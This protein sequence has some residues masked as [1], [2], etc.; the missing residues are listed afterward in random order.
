MS[1]DGDSND[2]ASDYSDITHINNKLRYIR[3]TIENKNILN[4]TITATNQKLI[5]NNFLLF[6][7]LFSL[8]HGTVIACLS[9]ATARLGDDLGS[10]QS[11][12]MY[13]SYTLSALLGAGPAVKKLGG[14]GKG[15]LVFAMW[16]YSIYVGGFLIATIISGDGA[17]DYY[18]GRGGIAK[19]ILVII[20][21]LLGGVGGG[22]LWTAQGAYFAR[23]SAEYAA[24]SDL[25]EYGIPKMTLDDASKELG[26][27]FATIKMAGE[28]VMRIFSS[29]AVA[30]L[31]WSWTTIFLV[32]ASIMVATAL[33]T[34]TTVIHYS[35]EEGIDRMQ[36]LCTFG[37]ASSI[38]KLLQTESKM[39][40]YMPF[41]MV[42]SLTKAFNLSFVNGEI[43]TLA[44]EDPDTTYVGLLGSFTA[45]IAA[46]ASIPF[47]RLA[48]WTGNRVVMIIGCIALL[49][50]SILFIT[51]PDTAEWGVGILIAVYG[52]QGIGISAYMG[53][54]RAEFVVMFAH[55]KENA[56][57]NIVWCWGLFNAIAHLLSANLGCYKVST[58]CIEYLDGSLRSIL[59]F[60][61]LVV[62]CLVIAIWCLLNV[63][64]SVLNVPSTKTDYCTRYS[65]LN[66]WCWATMD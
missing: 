65:H 25:D 4:N 29:V 27:Q 26:G 22:F 1:K 10:Y 64:R 16:I 20:A 39:K 59:P 60:E 40:Y 66:R 28:F 47:A 36:D 49:I 58:Y 8:N 46:L 21:G 45:M 38:L 15:G 43:L 5:L 56:F 23:V 13:I 54:L 41:I 34:T 51:I 31:G 12:I 14:S 61:L 19:D 53:S 11:F 57:A 3:N 33:L 24:T 2:T 32:Y 62:T 42:V 9:L 63:T 55:E 18:G 48:N 44:L 6:S 17:E 37:E 50:Q 35:N 30:A 7:V 52:L